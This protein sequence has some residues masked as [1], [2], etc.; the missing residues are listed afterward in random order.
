MMM[1]IQR[2]MK[3]NKPSYIIAQD[4]ESGYNNVRWELLL[5]KV[6]KEIIPNIKPSQQWIKS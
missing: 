4:V 2:N 5:K 1:Q 6:Q 3:E